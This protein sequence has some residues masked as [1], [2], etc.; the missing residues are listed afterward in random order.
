M[1]EPSLNIWLASSNA[2]TILLALLRRGQT[3]HYLTIH[4]RLLKH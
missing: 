4:D 2:N 1:S 3:R